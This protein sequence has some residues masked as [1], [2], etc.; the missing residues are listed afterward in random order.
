M[1]T[2]Q[3]LRVTVPIQRRKIFK[4]SLR[5]I[6]AVLLV[7]SILTAAALTY[8]RINGET[9]SIVEFILTSRLVGAWIALLIVGIGWK[10][11]Q[12]FLYYVSYFYDIDGPNFVIKKGIVAK[13]EVTLPFSRITDVYLDQDVLDVFFGLYDLHIST[14]TAESGRFAH[15]DGLDRRGATQLRELILARIQQDDELRAIDLTNT[16]PIMR[17]AI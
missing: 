12:P 3:P 1:P 11:S 10:L 2:R 5:G 17:K 4:S 13:R 6:T 15:I 16:K 14:P 7:W 8:A 9:R